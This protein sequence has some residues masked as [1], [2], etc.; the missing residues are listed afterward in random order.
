MRALQEAQVSGINNI[1]VQP[2]G[3]GINVTT[4]LTH[5]CRTLAGRAVPEAQGSVK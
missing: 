3:D 1:V 2:H 5:S 4:G